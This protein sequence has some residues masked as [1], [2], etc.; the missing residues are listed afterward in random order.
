MPWYNKRIIFFKQA[1]NR[2]ICNLISLSWNFQRATAWFRPGLGFGIDRLPQRLRT[3][4]IW[5]RTITTME[6]AMET[7]VVVL[8]WQELQLPRQLQKLLTQATRYQSMRLARD[9]CTWEP[10]LMMLHLICSRLLLSTVWLQLQ[11]YLSSGEI[12][13]VVNQTR[14]KLWQIIMLLLPISI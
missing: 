11:L 4:T 6:W 1:R 10:L 5:T 14:G 12:L 8:V 3:W 7:A 9:S 13:A 2:T